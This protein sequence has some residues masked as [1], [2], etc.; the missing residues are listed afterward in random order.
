MGE[1]VRLIPLFQERVDLA[2]Q[3]VLGGGT[4]EVGSTL[5]IVVLCAE[6]GGEGEV[7]EGL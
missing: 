7:A 4:A 2:G 6:G 1:C 3:R 5:V